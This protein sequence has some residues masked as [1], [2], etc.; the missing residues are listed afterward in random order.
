MK[1]S[2]GSSYQFRLIDVLRP[3]HGRVLAVTCYMLV[4]LMM[5]MV[6]Y[7]HL[8]NWSWFDALYMSVVTVSSVGFAETHPLSDAGRAFTMFLLA[9]GMIGLGA[10]WAT[11]TALIVE[12]D[13]HGSLRRWRMVKNMQNMTSHFIVCGAGRMGRAVV[14]ELERQGRKYIVTDVDADRLDA[15]EEKYPNGTFYCADATTEAALHAMHIGTAV[16]L[17]A[18]LPTDADNL[19]L[20]LTARGLRSDVHV[21]ARAECEESLVKLRRAGASEAISPILSGAVSMTALLVEHK[22]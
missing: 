3:H 11:V 6:G 9:T 10:W 16:G 2:G 4:V 14:G 15:L 7:V 8:E 20:C 18:C 22:Q 1:K 17:A 21:V 13:L 5:G 19:L 12:S